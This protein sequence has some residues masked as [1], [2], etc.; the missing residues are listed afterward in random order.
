MYNSFVFVRNIIELNMD[1]AYVIVVGNEKGGSGKTTTSMHLIISLMDL[2]FKVGCMDLDIRQRSISHYLMNRKK[3]ID[4]NNLDLMMPQHFVPD[5]SQAELKS[6]QQAEELEEFNKYFD[7]LH[8]SCEFIILDTPGSDIYL[9]RIAHGNADMII[10][11]INDSFVDIDLL[12]EVDY[13]GLTIKKPG[14]Y[15]TMIWEQK[16]DR[17]KNGNRKAIEWVV[18]RNRLSSNRAKNRYNVKQV[19]EELSKRIGFRI[20]S[21]F[22]DRVIFKELFLH[23]LTLIDIMSQNV[24]VRVSMSHVTARQELRNF[25]KSLNIPQLNKKLNN[26][27]S[28]LRTMESS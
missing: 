11:P 14:V 13:D 6:E 22:G 18:I 16:L 10:T 3:F 7:H 12:A 21:G 5:F 19:L 4:N 8:K 23:G 20:G 15:S 9:S 17:A 25:L 26:V 28:D 1:E 2:G 27:T 24:G